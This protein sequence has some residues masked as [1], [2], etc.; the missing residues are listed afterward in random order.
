M[1]RITIMLI[2]FM[3]VLAGCQQQPPPPTTAPTENLPTIIPTNTPRPTAVPTR[4]PTAQPTATPVPT[5]TATPVSATPAE[6]VS[7]VWVSSSNGL[8]LR[9][10]GSATAAVIVVVP[11]GQHLTAIG[12]PVGPDAA[13]VIWQNVR[14]DAGQSGWVAASLQGTALLSTTQPGVTASTPVAPGV[15]ATPPAGATPAAASSDVWVIAT[16]GLNLRTEP[17]TTATLITNVPFGQHLTAIGPQSAADS[18]GIAWQQA[19][20]DA[21]QT[22]WVAAVIQ[23]TPYLSTSQLTP[24]PTLPVPTAS[25]GGAPTNASAAATDLFNRINALRAQRGLSPYA[26]NNQLAVA[27]LAHSQDMASM[28]RIDHAGSDGSSP[29]Q[30]IKAAGY[31]G[32]FASENIYGGEAS[33]DDAWGYWSTDS[34]HLP[35]LISTQFADI[36]IGVYSVGRNTFYTADFGGQ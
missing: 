16:N 11:F 26:W 15:T 13:G 14:T 27:A 12:R 5:A 4:T 20:T 7:D 18:A 1:K 32:R 10:Q 22:G 29:A 21:G 30:R 33:V 28:G 31:N 9:D 3:T 36:G 35:N 25:A 17:K 2:V 8:N 24:V 23:G 6:T 19:R 34:N